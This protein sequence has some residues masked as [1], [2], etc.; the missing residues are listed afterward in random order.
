MSGLRRT[1]TLVGDDV[2]EYWR[3]IHQ[4]GYGFEPEYMESK[5]DPVPDT[6]PDQLSE[7]DPHMMN[8]KSLKRDCQLFSA[9]FQWDS[10][11]DESLDMEN[12]QKG[13]R[14]RFG[15]NEVLIY[16][17]YLKET[18]EEENKRLQEEAQRL[19]EEERG[20]KLVFRPKTK[21]IVLPP[22]TDDK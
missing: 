12:I 19:E 10:A 22:L 3:N 7:N 8:N 13:K 15:T 20:L 16:D 1:R 21:T 11:Y 18:Y 4:Q 17:R 14:V 6:D 2:I 9:I 5:P